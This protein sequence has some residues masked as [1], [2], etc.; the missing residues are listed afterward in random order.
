METDRAAS[1]RWAGEALGGEGLSFVKR[2]GLG[3]GAG[4]AFPA[5]RVASAEA[6]GQDRPCL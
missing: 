6:L 1:D 5:E 3:S 2:E 4:R